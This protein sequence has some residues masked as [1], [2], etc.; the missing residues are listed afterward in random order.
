[1]RRWLMHAVLTTSSCIGPARM[2]AARLSATQQE[3]YFRSA[4]SLLHV[5]RAS[6]CIL[7]GGAERAWERKSNEGY[8]S[9]VAQLAL[10]YAYRT[11]CRPAKGLGRLKER[12]TISLS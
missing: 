5:S 9:V 12:R 7:A 11:Y 1:M 6:W 4:L 3:T 10:F 2:P 8:K